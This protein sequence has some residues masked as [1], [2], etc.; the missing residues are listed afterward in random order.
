MKVILLLLFGYLL[1]S[2]SPAALVSKLKRKNLRKNGTGNL[3]ATNV[4]LNFGKKYGALV[5]LLDIAKAFVTVKLAA[6]L[7]PAD[8]IIPL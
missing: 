1:G 8:T 7:F 5:M 4:M 6:F 3:G 2:L